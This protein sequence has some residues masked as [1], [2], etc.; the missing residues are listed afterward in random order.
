MTSIRAILTFQRLLGNRDARQ[1]DMPLALN[2][3]VGEARRS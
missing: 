1:T 3:V 2:V